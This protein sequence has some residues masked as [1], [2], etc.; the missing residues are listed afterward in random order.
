MLHDEAADVLR[1]DFAVHRVADIAL[2]LIDEVQDA[3]HRDIAL[4][5]RPYDAV[6]DLVALEYL[7]AAIVLDDHERELLDDFVRREALAAGTALAAAAY[8]HAVIRRARVDDAAVFVFTI[9]TSHTYTFFT[10]FGCLR[11]RTRHFGP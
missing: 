11:G 6:E 9:G 8:R 5:T 10:C 4:V 3:L 2:D 1:G 7:A